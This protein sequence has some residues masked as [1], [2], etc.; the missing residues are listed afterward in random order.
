MDVFW[1]E[2][3]ESDVSANDVWLSGYEADC[4]ARMKFP[5][6]RADWRLGR[7]TA[8]RGIATV[9]ALS[10]EPAQLCRISIRAAP[11]G[12][13]EAFVD[14]EPAGLAISLSHRQ[15]R[16]VCAMTRGPAAL[17][18]DLEVVEP[19]ST[20][21]MT[22]YFAMEEL[23][24]L[25]QTSEADHL[26]TL[27]WSAKESALKALRTGL[28]VDTREVVVTGIGDPFCRPCEMD[29]SNRKSSL[30][31]Q[32]LDVVCRTGEV[33]QG[34]WNCTDRLVRT[35]IGAGGR[36]VLNILQMPAGT[37]ESLSMST[38][39]PVSRPV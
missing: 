33:L 30:T 38:A 5:K 29:A 27:L 37:P 11:S 34:W 7:W 2:Q 39:Q 36:P 35:V 24:L 16:A 8:K 18:C 31:W 22:D 9:L 13:P 6:R 17:G 23:A 12:A 14:E 25:G 28:R 32:F 21:F 15:R 1:F 4:L 10:D 20:A 19:R 26:A 3:R